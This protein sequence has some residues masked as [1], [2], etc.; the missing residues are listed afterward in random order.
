MDVGAQLRGKCHRW[1]ITGVAGFIG[2]HLLESLLGLQQSVTGIDNF[3]T[4]HRRNLDE[5][6]AIVGEQAWRGFRLI[7]GDIR[8]FDACR[9]ACAGAD[10]VLHQ[11]ALGSVSRSID[12]PML[13]NDINV[14][15]FVT[16]LTAARD[17]GVRRF[18]YASSSAVYGD[19][20]RLPKLEWQTGNA[21]SP[22]ALSKYVDELYAGVFARCYGIETIGLRY[23]NVFGPRQDPAGAYAAVIPRWI[24]AMIADRRLLINGDGE[25]SRD[26][27][28]V[29]N[30]VQANVLAALN[31]NPAATNQVFNIAVQGRTTLNTL[32]QLLRD[33]LVGRY[34]HLRAYRPHHG[35]FR[36]GDVR[37]SQA[38]I[39]RTVALLG[40]RPTHDIALGLAQ[41]I[42]WYIAHLS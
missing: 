28:H 7:V 2:S 29:A 1:V 38:D 25:T 26:F 21:L 40:Y 37:H 18:V 11:A 42:P 19:D 39:S 34:P 16:M 30:V 10:F 41:S 36:A 4:G 14:G 23:F 31:G 12:E 24:G 15:G 13:Y 33:L 3:S 35:D 8:K 9:D 6:R 5:V 32:Y 22:Y 17:R 20:P 27:C